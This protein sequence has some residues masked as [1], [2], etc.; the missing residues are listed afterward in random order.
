M[1]WPIQRQRGK[2]SEGMEK[3][4]ARKPLIYLETTMFNHYFDTD[5][6]AHPATVRL[7]KEIRA[8]M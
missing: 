5:R 8:G 7:F 6:D 3:A 1:Y 4:S 2:E